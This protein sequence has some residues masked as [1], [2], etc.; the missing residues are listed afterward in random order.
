MSSRIGF[1]RLWPPSGPS[2]QGYSH[3][4]PSSKHPATRIL[5]SGPIG[6]GK[7]TVGRLLAARGALVV[8]AD[9]VGHAMLEPSGPAHTGVAARWPQVVEDGRIDRSALA[10]IVFAD[11]DELAALEALTHP[12]IRSHIIEL[13]D[14]AADQVFVVELP[15]TIDLMGPGWHRLVVIA[16]E[17]L[18]LLRA[19]AR[20]MDERDVRH[21]MSAQATTQR[22]RAIAD[23][24]IVNDG[25][26]EEL[27]R[28]VADWWDA[29]VAAGSI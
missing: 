14:A 20:G 9:K 5:L 25:D 19:I 11:G 8:D 29:T 3:G 6:S 22:W 15:L 27:E 2:A 10:A 28:N 26:V 7:S 1:P 12:H 4:V 23:A 18:R 17:E 16:D 21:R 24:V 13:A